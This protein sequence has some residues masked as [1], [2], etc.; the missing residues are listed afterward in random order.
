L[1]PAGRARRAPGPL[2]PVVLRP[3]G[4][5]PVNT[6][7]FS[8]TLDYP[9]SAS[10]APRWGYGRPFHP[11]IA[12]LLARHVATYEREL[13]GVARHVED[14]RRIPV[15]PDA[16]APREPAW[17]NGFLPGL[18]SA[19]LYGLMRDRRPVRY[20]EIGSGN[21]TKFVARARRDG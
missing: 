5:G 16:A 20:M 4:H 15:L 7:G 14:M 9:P 13:R 2:R 8:I 11:R 12:A 1:P 10:N 6:A 21:S 3:R 19:L 18:D 17:I